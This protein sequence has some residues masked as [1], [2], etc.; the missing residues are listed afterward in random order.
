[1]SSEKVNID[2]VFKAD[3]TKSAS[4]HWKEMME[5]FGWK[6]QE[7]GAYFEKFTEVVNEQPQPNAP[8]E[9]LQFLQKASNE[10]YGPRFYTHGTVYHNNKFDRY[11]FMLQ[12]RDKEGKPLATSKFMMN[13][14]YFV[15]HFDKAF[16]LA[17]GYMC[18]AF[19]RTYN[20]RWA[21]MTSHRQLHVKNVNPN[22]YT[23]AFTYM[24][25][26]MDV[27]KTDKY[28]KFMVELREEVAIITGVLS[29]QFTA[30]GY[31]NSGDLLRKICPAV[32]S[33][34]KL[35]CK[36]AQPLNVESAIIHLNDVSIHR[37]E[38]QKWSREDIADWLESL[39]V[40]LTLQG[41]K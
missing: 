7:T 29:P 34:V 37:G 3:L 6:A 27:L 20:Y 14:D 16:E 21:Q 23:S 4:F 5:H 40:D 36:C 38:L 25:D 22:D 10:L 8:M 11:N 30:A 17:L 1:M 26:P 15:T 13:I 31:G 12:L 32:L 33:M 41:E 24:E 35:P 9:L 19:K 2:F 28:K 39:D 18:D